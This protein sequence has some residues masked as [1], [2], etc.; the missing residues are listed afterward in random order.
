MLRYLKTNSD[1]YNIIIFPSATIV[2][3]I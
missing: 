2:S 3:P 1:I